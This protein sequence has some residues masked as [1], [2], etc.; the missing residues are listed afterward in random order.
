MRI[1]ISNIAWQKEEDEKISKLLNK[2]EIDAIDI[3][4]SKYF[5]E[6]SNTNIQDI[7]KVRNWWSD[8][9]IEIIGMQSLLYGTIGLNLFDNFD[10]QERM[11]KHL[12]EVCRIAHYLNAKRL[13]FGS[14]RNRDRS[15]LS[16]QKALEIATN[17]FK[18]LAEIAQKYNV[19]VCLEP[20]PVCYGSNFM[21]TSRETATIVSEVNH[22]AIKM[23]F[24]TGALS[25]NEEDPFQVCL[26]Y[27][28]L[29]GH[30]HLSD[31][32]LTPL[33]LTPGIHKDV[34]TALRSSLPEFPVTI[35]MLIKSPNQKDSI[36]EES[37]KFITTCYRKNTLKKKL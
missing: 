23:Q 36:L 18:K 13:V 12:E 2:Y 9:G 1:S 31:P 27:K 30:I 32:N 19:I 28:N 21:T 20:N 11:L 7:L 26:Q 8:R 35:E 25:I 24:D 6:F 29:I 15:G 34:A 5:S 3:A 37:L 33:G 4:P 17:F 22:P 14:P 10:I 16:N